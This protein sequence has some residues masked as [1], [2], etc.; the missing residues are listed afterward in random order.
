MM[1]TAFRACVLFA[2]AACGPAVSGDDEDTT[3]ATLLIEPALS[4]HVILNGV[5]AHQ[6]FTATLKFPDGH[7]RD[8]TDETSF[9]IDSAF[10]TFT[11]NDLALGT[12]LLYTSDAADE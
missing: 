7:L 8:V 4:E 3:A 1:R 6:E 10:G 2:I 9:L 12:C 11:E 5:A